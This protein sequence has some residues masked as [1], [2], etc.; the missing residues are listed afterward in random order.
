MY[1]NLG[2][3]LFIDNMVL[4]LQY[5]TNALCSSRNLKPGV[6]LNLIKLGNSGRVQK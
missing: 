3:V 5:C 1:Q 2:E 4:L 6:C